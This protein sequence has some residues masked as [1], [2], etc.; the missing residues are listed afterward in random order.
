MDWILKMVCPKNIFKNKT[1]TTLDKAIL[2]VGYSF[3]YITYI[4]LTVTALA[5]IV[6]GVIKR[7]G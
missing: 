3:L 4:T 7:F 2:W 1:L 6:W 5:F